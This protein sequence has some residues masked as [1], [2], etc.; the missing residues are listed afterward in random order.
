MRRRT[1]LRN[2]A[3]AGAVALS[4]GCLTDA[5]P[6]DSTDTETDDGSSPTLD[7]TAFEVT[8]VGSGTQV[9]EAA[10]TT[11][12]QQVVV[13]GTIH[14]SNGCYT[15]SLADATFEDGTLAVT[16]ESHEKDTEGTA[17][18]VCTDAIVEIEYRLEATFAGGMPGTVEVTHDSPSGLKVVTTEQMES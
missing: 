7:D 2:A 18:N 1:L 4:A 14:G 8:N 13:T 6:G 12:G 10:V 3:A 15:A 5:G 17:T 16:V 9:D 11:D